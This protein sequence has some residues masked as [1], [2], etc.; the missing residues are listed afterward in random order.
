M[1]FKFRHIVARKNIKIYKNVSEKFR[2]SIERKLF[3]P[4]LAQTLVWKSDAPYAKL[5]L[6]EEFL[7]VNINLCIPQG[8]LFM[9]LTSKV[10]LR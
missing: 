2:R 7:P 4:I 5:Y 8:P 10:F 6:H 3:V 9:H 1:Y